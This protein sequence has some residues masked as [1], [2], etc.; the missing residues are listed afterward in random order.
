MNVFKFGGASVKNAEA[1]KNV[2]K[3]LHQYADLELIV[4]ISAMGKMTNH[5]EAIL[6]ASPKNERIILISE[7]ENFHSHIAKELGILD[8]FLPFLNLRISELQSS[9][10]KNLDEFALYDLVVSQGELTSTRLI[11]CYL[12]HEGFNSAWLDARTVIS[13]E[14]NHKVTNVNWNLSAAK[15]QILRS[16][17][18]NHRI[19]ITQGFIASNSKGETTTLGREGSDF[20]ASIL[21]YLTSAKSVTIWKDV[22]GMLNADP[23]WFEDTIKLNKISYREAIELA[24]YGASVIHP[25]TVKPLQNLSI[26]LHVKSFLDSE[27]E[28]TVISDGVKTEPLVPSYIFKQNQILISFIPKDFSFV[29]ETHLSEIFKVL[30]QDKTTVNLMQNSAVSF[31]VVADSKCTNLSNIQEKLGHTFSIKFNNDLELLTIRHYDENIVNKLTSKK[32]ILIEQKNRNT[33]R[34]VISN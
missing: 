25:K 3:I 19:I 14:D 8:E 32:K 9:F 22:P 23:R 11:D 2:A 34:L 21:A 20:S 26:P 6:D 24:Y 15:S 4:V 30:A 18:A 29:E 33:M 31:S 10:D 28:G 17:S 13:T 27:A 12:K 7:F 16:L 5:L 1:V